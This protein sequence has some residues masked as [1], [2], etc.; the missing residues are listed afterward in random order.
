MQDYTQVLETVRKLFVYPDEMN[1]KGMADEVF[2]ENVLMDYSSFGAGE[3]ITMK[4]DDIIAQWEPFFAK[5]DS[6][7]H[8]LGNELVD[9]AE[10]EAKVSAYVMAGHYKEMQ[11]GDNLWT[12]VGTY[13]IK[14]FNGKNGW[15]VTEMKFNY[16]YQEGNQEI[17]KQGLE[18]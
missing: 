10:K 2:A 17:Q 7:H 16:K 9:I 11:N 5:I 13:N 8:Q 6:T 3:P 15:R 14:L 18:G 12:V 1:W 4:R